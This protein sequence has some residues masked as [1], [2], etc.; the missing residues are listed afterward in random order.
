M[1][2]DSRSQVLCKYKTNKHGIT[3][4]EIICILFVLFLLFSI[5]M[6]SL[7]KCR[8]IAS[9]VV[10]S[11]NMKGLGTAI[12]VYLNDSSDCFPDPEQWLFKK[13]SYSPEHP[14]GC[15]WHDWVMALDGELMQGH[16]D[17]MGIT[18]DLDLS[19]QSLLCPDLRDIAKSR[20]CENPDHNP[21]LPIRPQFNYT[22]NAYLGSDRSGGVL[23]SDQV[24]KP[25]RIFILGEENSWSVRPDHPQYP[26]EW[27]RAPLSTKALDD[28]ALL[29]A[30]TP[31][32]VN[33][34]ATHHGASKNKDNGRGNLVYLDGHVDT[35][36]A[37]Q[38]LRQKMHGASEPR[39]SRGESGFYHPAGNLY[40]AWPGEAPPPG[41]WDA[42]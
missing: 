35:I 9:R 1:N 22:M 42:Q 20:G 29:I 11:S 31:E 19:P 40:Y 14:E 34:F 32:A 39:S 26:A 28:T 21:N 30:P 8:K 2:P 37:Y 5:L 24:Y 41:G 16:T 17:Y 12:T 6:P 18:Y 10:C 36:T 25:A 7:S 4:L 15:R 33:C 27:L 38:Q 13:D 3:L 23:A